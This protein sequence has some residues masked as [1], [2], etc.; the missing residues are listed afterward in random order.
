MIT[1]KHVKLRGKKKPL[2]KEREKKGKNKMKKLKET[3]VKLLV[4]FVFNLLVEIIFNQK[5]VF[6]EIK[7]DWNSA[8]ELFEFQR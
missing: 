6:M 7:Q 5:K 8:F 3:K 4:L 1:S 2:V